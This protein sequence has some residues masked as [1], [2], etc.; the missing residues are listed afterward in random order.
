[1]TK[2]CP[3]LNPLQ[4]D[5]TSQ[6]QRLLDALLPENNPIDERSQEDLLVYLQKYAALLVYYD[7][8]NFPSGNWKDFIE[9]EPPNESSDHPPHMVLLLAFLKLFSYLQEH[10][11]TLTAK[12]LDFYYRDTLQLLRKEERPDQVHLIFELAKQID[13]HRLEKEELFKAGKDAKGKNRFYGSNDELAINKAVL[14]EEHG[15]K[16]VFIEK[17][18]SGKVTGIHAASY[19]NSS[20]GLG[21]DIEDKEGKW[22]TFG[23]AEMPEATLGFAVASPMFYLAEGERKITV[24]FYL[25]SLL[26][27]DIEIIENAVCKH[28]HVF[29][30]VKINGHLVH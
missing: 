7:V 11:N 25:E 14:S 12:H 30:V 4:R 19:A 15:L 6:N 24:K 8:N 13:Q 1:M 18:G 26:A 5:G 3:F 27:S 23:S 9:L 16:T 10:L 22:E 17:S 2:F 20:D 29:I 28:V 21:A